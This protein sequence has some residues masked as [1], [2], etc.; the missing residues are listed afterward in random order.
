MKFNSD[1]LSAWHSFLL[2]NF[3][4]I[5]LDAPDEYQNE[6][7]KMRSSAVFSHRTFYFMRLNPAAVLIQLCHQE[8]KLSLCGERVKASPP[9]Y[10][11]QR[12]LFQ[13]Y[14]AAGVKTIDR[15]SLVSFIRWREEGGRQAGREREGGRPLLPNAI[16]QPTQSAG[17]AH[18]GRQLA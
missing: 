10:L 3:M 17:N 1:M 16:N 7:K 12:L 9:N 18:C 11:P 4:K 2:P 15:K 8:V 5:S 13:I 6:T 14:V